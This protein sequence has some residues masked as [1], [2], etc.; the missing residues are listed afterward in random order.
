MKT[1]MRDRCDDFEQVASLWRRTWLDEYKGKTW[2]V[3]PDAAFFQWLVGPESGAICHYGYQGEEL[4]GCVFSAPYALRIGSIVKPSALVFGLTVKPG[5]RGLT[6]PLVERMRR[7][8]AERGIGLTLGIVVNDENSASRLFWTKYAQAFPQN[9][10]FLFSLGQWVKPLAPGHM[11]KASVEP[12]QRLTAGTL[13]HLFSRIPVGG[14]PSV[15]RYR[16]SDLERCAE[17][18]NGASR[19]LDWSLV[20]TPEQI[21]HR[22]EGPTCGAMVL[23]RDGVVRGVVIYHAIVMHGREQVL[24]AA[25]D[26]WADDGLSNPERIRLLAELCRHLRDSGF[27]VVS[28]LRCAMMPTAAFLANL[29]LPVPAPWCVVAVWSERAVPLPL[30][31][32]WGLL[33]M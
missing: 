7:F 16:P 19:G 26:L 9:L 30:P 11:S 10:T 33:L 1:E 31:K 25:I 13:G 28:A 3:T 17:L 15:R 8:N 32:R 18:V 12:W 6:L 5:H 24:G 20:W 22:L 14:G 29:F 23:E 21:R 2:V 27:H 4:V